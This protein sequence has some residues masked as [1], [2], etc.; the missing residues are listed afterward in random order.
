MRKS[1]F[2]VGILLGLGGFAVAE[3]LAG[4]DITNKIGGKRV[5]L[6]TMGLQ[7]PLVYSSS[8]A[9]TGDGTAVGLSRY[10]NP[11]ETGT[12]WVQGDKL[13]QRFPT[14]YQGKTW[15][16]KLESAGNNRL[17]WQR[18]DGFSGKAIIAG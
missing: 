1:V 18:D 16:F 10:F 8:G 9:V 5:V 3:P 7:F 17:R 14:W 2:T 6:Q 12:W 4:P 11:K 13:C 15:C